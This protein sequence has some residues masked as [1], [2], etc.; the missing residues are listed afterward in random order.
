MNHSKMRNQQGV[1]HILV[2]VGLVVVV[3]IGFVGWRIVDRHKTKQTVTTASQSAAPAS[4]NSTSGSAYNSDLNSINSSMN[5][6]N[7]DSS[8]AST[9]VNDSNSQ[10]AVPTN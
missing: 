8:S 10:I 1:G 9:A 2:I 6:E 4:T 7:S 3:A 5:Q